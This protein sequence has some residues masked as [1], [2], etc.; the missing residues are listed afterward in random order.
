VGHGKLDKLRQSLID[1][2][3]AQ[4]YLNSVDVH[5][6]SSFSTPFCEDSTEGVV[7]KGFGH[8]VVHSGGKA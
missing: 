4:C 3:I 1:R 2:R 6:G 8:I 7:G 5:S